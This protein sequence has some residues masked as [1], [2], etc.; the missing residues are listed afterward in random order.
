VSHPSLLSDADLRLRKGFE[1]RTLRSGGFPHREHVRLTWGYL[2]EEPTSAVADRLCAAL[3]DY[4][5]HHGAPEKFH[6]TLTRVW[7]AIVADAVRQHPDLSFE[8]MV[9]ACPWLLD[10][11]APARWYTRARLYS[12]DARAG[13]VAPDLEPLP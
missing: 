6:H 13:F 1:R 8:A 4:A 2:H 12:P 11:E 9:A 7:V 5:E 10:K 3:R